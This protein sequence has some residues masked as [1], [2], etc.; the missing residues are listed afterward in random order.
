M[1][2]VAIKELKSPQDPW[3]LAPA[4]K[5]TWQVEVVCLWWRGGFAVQIRWCHSKWYSNKRRC[6]RP[7]ASRPGDGEDEAVRR[8]RAMWR[9]RRRG[10]AVRRT[11]I[12]SACHHRAPPPIQQPGGG[13]GGGPDLS[14]SR[15]RSPVAMLPRAWEGRGIGFV[16]SRRCR[17][18]APQVPA[19][20]HRAPRPHQA[21]MRRRWRVAG[22]CEERAS[23]CSHR[24]RH[25]RGGNEDERRGGGRGRGGH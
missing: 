8:L 18:A 2:Y 24:G 10:G 15:S 16:G 13:D 11:R 19:R 5:S 7:W 21:T 12:P 23:P 17:R 4:S 14:R 25:G 1:Q 22:A 9:P 6:G 3:Y 20:R